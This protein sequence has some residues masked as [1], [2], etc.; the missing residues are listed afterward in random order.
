MLSL[1]LISISLSAVGSIPSA[2]ATAALTPIVQPTNYITS[3]SSVAYTYSAAYPTSMPTICD[4]QFTNLWIFQNNSGKGTNSGIGSCALGSAG[5]LRHFQ[6]YI[7][8]PD[9]G[10]A[11][12]QLQVCEVSNVPTYI[13]INSGQPGGGVTINDWTTHS[14]QS[15]VTLANILSTSPKAPA[16]LSTVSL[17]N[18]QSVLTKIQLS[19]TSG[20]TYSPGFTVDAW[21]YFPNSV[22][23]VSG[24]VGIY[25]DNAACNGNSTDNTPYAAID[26]S[27]T[28]AP[29]SPAIYSTFASAVT[30][31][32][33]AGK[34]PP[35]VAAASSPS[36]GPTT[37]TATLAGTIVPN[38][39]LLTS[40]TFKYGTD[41]T[42]A[43]GST[44]T[45]ISQSLTGWSDATSH[46]A[47]LALT[48]LTAYTTYYYELIGT[49]S[50]GS[51]T[52][53]IYS[54]TTLGTAASMVSV[55]ITGTATVGQVLT[56]TPSSATGAP[57]PT[58]S[59]QWQSA[60]TSGGTY[61]NIPTSGA[62]STYTLK[63][64]DRGMFVR[65]SSWASNAVGTST[66]VYSSPTTAVT[67]TNFTVTYLNNCTMNCSGT[68]AAQTTNATTNLTTNTFAQ[69]G[70]NFA[71]WNT[72]ADG[73]GS[74]Y[75]NSAPY[76]F[77]TSTT[78]YAQ[79]VSNGVAITYSVTFDANGGT[80]SMAN[81]TSGSSAALTS[82]QYTRPNY[83]F[84]GWTTVPNGSGTAYANGATYA[85]GASTNLYA[86]W[87]P[88]TYT[89]T[90]NSH[91][92]SGGSSTTS[93]QTGNVTSATGLTANTF[94][95]TGYNF[96]G[97][98]S[99]ADGTGTAFANDATYAFDASLTLY[100][101]WVHGTYSISFN[102]NGGTGSM[103]DQTTD[104]PSALTKNT[105]SF[106]NESFTGWNT[107]ANG[108]GTA[109]SDQAVYPF[110]TSTTLY[111]QWVTKT[112]SPQSITVS[113]ASSSLAYNGTTTLSTSG[114]S[115]SA[116]GIA[117]NVVGN[118]SISGNT[119]TAISGS[120]TCTAS[121]VIAADSN[122]SSA[123][124][125]ALTI[126]LTTA[127]QAITPA[128]SAPANAGVN[129][130]SYTPSA[131]SGSGLPVAIAIDASSSTYCSMTSGVVTFNNPGS[132]IINFTQAGNA[133]YSAATRVQQSVT[134]IASSLSSVLPSHLTRICS[135]LVDNTT[136]GECKVSS[137]AT[138]LDLVIPQAAFATS[139]SVNTYLNN[140]DLNTSLSGIGIASYLLNFVV[141]WHKD[142]GTIPA[143]SKNLVL[144]VTNASIKKGM[145]IYV[146]GTSSKTALG[147]ATVDGSLTV[148]ITLDPQL[149][150]AATVPDAPTSITATA[151]NTAATV[152]WTAP[153]SDGGSA[154][155][156]YIV[157]SS[158]G[159]TCT[160]ADGATLSCRVTGLTNGTGYTFTVVA[161]NVVGNSL[162]S[163]ASSSVTPAQVPSAP[164][165]G[166]ATVS[167]ATTV[168]IPYT[169]G[170]NNGSVITSYVV[171]SSPSI[172]LNVSGAISPLTVTGSF[173]QG[174]AYTFSV[175]AV[176][177]IG[178]GSAATSNSVTPNVVAV[179]TPSFTLQPNNISVTTGQSFTLSATAI[180]TDGGTL[181]YKWYQ[182]SAP[183]GTNSSSYTVSSAANADAGSYSVTVTNTKSG[184]TT[185]A[186]P[187][188]TVTVTVAAALSITT[189]SGLTAIFGTPFTATL[190]TAGG[191]T[192]L[193][194]SSCGGFP[195]TDF[196][197]S[198]SGV[199]TGTPTSVG[200]VSSLCVQAIDS[201]Y[202][203][204]NIGSSLIQTSTFSIQVN[205]AVITTHNVTITSPTD[206]ATPQ[207]STSD[208]G[209][210]TSTISWAS[211]LVTFTGG[212]IY[213][214][215][216]FITPDSNYT[217]TGVSA[218]FFT[219]NG[220]A[221]TNVNAAGQGKFSYEFPATAAS[222]STTMLAAATTTPVYGATDLLSVTVTVGAT[223]TVTFS[224]A[225][226]TI[227]SAVTLVAGSAQ[228]SWTPAHAG[229][230]SITAEYSGD[231][232]YGSSSA[233]AVTVLVSKAT[234]S[235]S[236]FS[237]VGLTFGS[238]STVII[239]NPTLTPSISGTFTYSSATTS[240]ATLSGNTVTIIAPGSSLIT[241]TF[242][243]T[244]STDYNG[245]SASTSFVVAAAAP[246]APSIT[247]LSIIDTGTV[248][249]VFTPG[250]TNGLPITSYIVTA[251]P[252][253]SVS[254]VA[255]T[256]SPLQVTGA[257]VRGTSY[258]FTL[259]AV[260]GEGQGEASPVSASFTPYPFAGAAAPV[261]D[262]APSTNTT[263]LGQSV[264]LS[265]TAHSPDTGTLTYQW[266][267]N[268][269]A[270]ASANGASYTFIVGAST[271]T[272][273]YTVGITNTV[274]ANA[275]SAT[276]TT[277]PVTL[278]VTSALSLNTPVHS[279]TATIG[280][281]Y[282]L[283]VSAAGGSAPYTYSVSTG[284]SVLTSAGF[285]LDTSTGRISGTPTSVGTVTL[286]ITVV[287]A[288]HAT[289][290][291]SAFTI[292]IVDDPD[293]PLPTFSLPT[294][295]SDGFI[296]IVTN[297]DSFYAESAEVS[298]GSITAAIPSG[299]TWT[300]TVSGLLSGQSGT[301]T[302]TVSK[303]GY[304]TN[305]AIV[306][307]TALI[308]P[309]ASK[310]VP[311]PLQQSVISS[312]SPSSATV[313]YSVTV[314]ITGSFVETVSN[315]AIGS[316]FLPAGSWNQTPS[317]ISFVMPSSAVGSYGVQIF[318]G[319]APVL[320]PNTFTF[321][322]PLPIPAVSPTP[323]ATPIPL[324]TPKPR[325]TP[326]PRATTTP[327][328]SA[329]PTPSTSPT[330]A[331]KKP[332]VFEFYFDLG[333]YQLTYKGSTA[334]RILA[335][336]ISGL[337]H[338]ISLS[339]IGF[340]QPIGGSNAAD[341]ALS[342]K[343][344]AVV[345]KFLRENGVNSTITYLGAGRTAVNAATSRVVEVVVSYRV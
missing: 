235:I 244:N 145:V 289:V 209:Q 344:A 134:V 27:F 206:G 243:P 186:V 50:T 296:V 278:A 129:V 249:V 228:C 49:N 69:T 234:P 299:S 22:A 4:T 141:E 33:V 13:A 86:Q 160:T 217:L 213:K 169:A 287:D 14:L 177:A 2:Q 341:I 307:G 39:D 95:Y 229:T 96:T 226:T 194:F 320:A 293:A 211:A 24:V 109:Y 98:N 44:T 166:T 207:T 120:G 196:S 303:A 172:S 6:S 343:R 37:T 284:G 264:T 167:N 193:T 298:A 117:Y 8:Y 277:A 130:G 66:V 241:A 258:T 36:S 322:A 221:A 295:T 135:N 9:A 271:A 91:N 197:V 72:K 119:V 18:G 170:T 124:S 248:S 89:V 230:Y 128:A 42:L 276:T 331:A 242:A 263:S 175:S 304:V 210:F 102:V 150:I 133:F 107:L 333:S 345:T 126:T 301:V 87:T 261:I 52:S 247:A 137:S 121:A 59:Y 67:G 340:A 35:T 265:V 157:T 68:M 158:G 214:A 281:A 131:T 267:R 139:T 168:S 65:A 51:Q 53:S 332:A 90:F 3:T 82:N 40:A 292:T 17:W 118:C 224:D 113:A 162:S 285:T 260:N 108:T 310:P 334:L 336:K 26:G 100:A 103:V 329:S 342:Q 81:Q 78:L 173:V 32:S 75:G 335:A 29:P 245:A 262:L 122:Y 151:S 231:L 246:G 215:T 70:F 339:V 25:F 330:T 182:G 155:T 46:A 61:A 240:V 191:K 10:A 225:S 148:N 92:P 142:D 204:A 199:I 74:N 318:N 47:S 43:S 266:N 306:T 88:I 97:W 255:G 305:S 254:V 179:A 327:T 188:N 23:G 38:N 203:G 41:P 132:C 256:T 250:A 123:N 28:T 116:A 200:T 323:K 238:A 239:T 282:L 19:Q 71:G 94:S 85:F 149:V 313:G 11:S 337:G 63:S 190:S 185:S 143:A 257:F 280:F 219:V 269:A 325:A 54:F 159:Q 111:A 34:N 237:V 147:T 253:L 319:S 233:T 76:S 312:M 195:T 31:S 21:A 152:S 183:V 84:S 184:I 115:G 12:P 164:T 127:S 154:I 187:S 315:I 73:T 316:S 297:Y 326:T 294:Q 57:T 270:I 16:V 80:G 62:L 275:T 1:A 104:A 153:A 192:P 236:S 83:T 252:S 338:A 161:V 93:T 181:T 222:S 165:L 171:S 273:T 144:T 106:I 101:Q 105:L 60:A 79:W 302:V 300:L 208:N 112:L 321:T 30:T 198:S 174:Q 314:T 259:T 146:V 156:S 138:S 286:A 272:D 223:G 216:I 220:N 227:C 58:I 48:G 176:N 77:T 309:V 201:N 140:T 218:N 15:T 328:P 290:S 163:S 125:N 212:T 5:I 136:G 274:L 311:D 232:S 279:L 64:A 251:T 114:S 291:T 110:T 202:N 288:L 56:A 317:T 180:S 189:P 55:S 308:T 178:T 45:A 268:G 324:A 7:D 99:L 205:P 20:L 283:S